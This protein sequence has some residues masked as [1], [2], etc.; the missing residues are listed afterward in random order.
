MTYTIDGQTYTTRT[1]DKGTEIKSLPNIAVPSKEGYTFGGWYSDTALTTSL[2]S[3][4]GTVTADMEVYG[5]WTPVTGTIKYDLNGGS[6][7]F[8]DQTKTYGQSLQLHMAAP[9]RTGFTFKGWATTATGAAVYQPGDMY[10]TEIGKSTVTLYAVWEQI[11]FTVTLPS[12]T[13]Y[14]VSTTQSTTVKR[15][16]AIQM[17]HCS[18]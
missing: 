16:T 10:A 18:K 3:A 17:N 5:K 4:S 15:L 6:G 14:S 7:S 9:T 2:S 11:T 13:G 1:V 12:G 8:A